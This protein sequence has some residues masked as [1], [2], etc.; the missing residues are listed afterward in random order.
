MK[1]QAGTD[2]RRGMT[3][4]EVL[5]TMSIIG[6]LIALLLPAV[7]FAR[8]TS[9][10]IQC[11]SHVR[12]LVIAFNNYHDSY[13]TFPGN[14]PGFGWQRASGPYLEINRQAESHALFRC[15][16]DPEATGQIG[17]ARSY[18]LNHGT[19]AKDGF[20][21][22]NR[23]NSASDIV[24]GLSQTAAVAERLPAPV[25]AGSSGFSW[26]SRPNDWKRRMRF[27]P[28]SGTDLKVLF[29]TCR[30]QSNPPPPFPGPEPFYTH[31]MTPN[32][33]SCSNGS[34]L[35]AGFGTT[36]YAATATSLHSGGVNVGFADGSV[37]FVAAQIDREVWWA[38]GQRADGKSIGSGY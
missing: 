14:A 22:Q 6:L 30:N 1:S 9:R 3:L 19:G 34:V 35:A 21:G 5:V 27:M 8:E 33:N 7:Q 32:E 4:L 26:S 31:V 12:Q 20:A 10:K 29:D 23:W 16:S 2:R 11:G 18:Q 36:P 13:G 17:A 38:L 24:D 37:H 28:Y 25:G 15:P